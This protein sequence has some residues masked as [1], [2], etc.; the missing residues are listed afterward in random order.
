MSFVK[1]RGGLEI[2][3]GIR[4]NSGRIAK[5]FCSYNLWRPIRDEAEHALR[6]IYAIIEG[7]VLA[8]IHAVVFIMGDNFVVVLLVEIN[9]KD[10]PFDFETTERKLTGHI[11]IDLQIIYGLRAVF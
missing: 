1:Y 10:L 8:E 9:I 5:L 2:S 11:K 4:S 7:E 6:D 3:V